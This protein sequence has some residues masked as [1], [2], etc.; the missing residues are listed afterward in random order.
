MTANSLG[1]L[2]RQKAHITPW[3]FYIIWDDQRGD[4]ALNHTEVAFDKIH[5]KI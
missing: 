4:S 2:K 1:Y 5:I 3:P